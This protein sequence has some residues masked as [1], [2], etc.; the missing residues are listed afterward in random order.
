MELR[1]CQNPNDN[2]RLVKVQYPSSI[3]TSSEHGRRIDA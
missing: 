3:E 1:E 2:L